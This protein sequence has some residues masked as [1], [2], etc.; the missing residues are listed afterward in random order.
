MLSSLLPVALAATA[1]YAQSDIPISYP[2][3]S[4]LSHAMSGPLYTYPTH[5]TQGIVPKALHS[6]NDYWRPIPFYSALSVGAVSVEADVWLYNGTLHVGHEESAL[7]NERTFDSLYIQ[8]ILSVLHAENPSS[9]FLTATTPTKN[10]VFDTASGQTLYLFV[11]VKTVGA[12]TWPYVVRALEPLRAAGYLTTYN[13]TAV[14]AG[15]VT[16]VGTGNTP[17]DQVQGVNATPANP[18]DYFY[19]APLAFLNTTFSNITAAVSPIASVDFAAQ[20]GAVRN[21][22]FNATQTALLESQIATAHAKGIAVRYWDQPGWPIGTRNAIWRI[23][24]DA[25]A[26]LINVDDLEGAANY[27]QG[28]G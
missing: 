25:G 27:W 28:L 23:L 3:Q 14:T 7:T 13:G 20:F 21:E 15:P 6:H 5:L 2:L 8:P 11:D 12:T 17:L 1:A 22:T 19:D 26:D 9:N 4:I 24:Y 18:R 10:G 16:V